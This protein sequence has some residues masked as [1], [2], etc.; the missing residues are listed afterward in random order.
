MILGF[1]TPEASRE[2]MIRGIQD[3]VD[4]LMQAGKGEAE[5]VRV[6]P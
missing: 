2:A 1:F 3:A 5:E 4:T 6:I